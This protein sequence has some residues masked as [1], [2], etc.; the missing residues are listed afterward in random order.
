MSRF[1]AWCLRFI[2]FEWI[3]FYSLV[4]LNAI[5]AIQRPF[6][7]SVDGPTHLYNAKV[8]A[9]LVL[10]DSEFL[11]QYYEF[12]NWIVPNWGGHVILAGLL[13]VFSGAVASKLFIGLCLVLLP[14]SF[15]YCVRKI[16]AE[17]IF[18]TYLIFPFTYTFILCMGFYNFYIGT[19]ILFMALGTLIQYQRYP[20][21]PGVFVLL[22]LLILLCYLCHI[23]VFISLGMTA[24]CLYLLDSIRIIFN[25]ERVKEVLKKS[26]FLFLAF[27]VPLLLTMSFFAH[28]SGVQNKMYLFKS[29]LLQWITQCRGIIWY[30][31]GEEFMYSMYVFFVFIFLFSIAVYI[32]S[33]QFHKDLGEKPTLRSFFQAFC[34]QDTFLLMLV[35][36]LFLYFRLPDS[37]SLAGFVSIRLNLMVFLFLI[38][39]CSGF[40]YPG[41]I[42]LVSFLILL[43]SQYSLLTMHNYSFEILGLRVT[44]IKVVENCI[45]ENTVILPL[46]YSKDWLVPHNSNYLGINKPVLILENHECNN[47]YFPL[48]W[49]DE[50]M[51]GYTASNDSRL[52]QFLRNSSPEVVD[53]IDYIFVQDKTSLPANVLAE[54]LKEYRLKKETKHLLLFENKAR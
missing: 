24:L 43:F 5:P 1:E 54:I 11:S 21:R 14:V 30:L 18:T 50:V 32:R 12:N 35:A 10:G 53:K 46:D 39:W 8:I 23:F 27:S 29:E 38:V 19:S 44:E 4:L 48:K 51:K 31:P 52:N 20:F 25:K 37:D 9:G 26:I 17:A 15:R 36:F 3:L 16:N 2:R 47:S 49:K 34:F 40:H 45:K 42:S 6:F 13:S 28:T 41:W 33:Q 22:S 7:H